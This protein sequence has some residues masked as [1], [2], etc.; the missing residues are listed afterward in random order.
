MPQL[1]TTASVKTVKAEAFGYLNAILYLAPHTIAGGPSVCPS[2][3]PGCR[4]SCLYTSGRGRH[5]NVQAARI[6]K[7]KLWHTDKSLFL[8][9]LNND[10]QLLAAQAEKKALKLAV[11]LNGTSD[12]PFYIYCTSLFNMWKEQGVTF[13]DY[14]KVHGYGKMLPPWWHLTFSLSEKN[15]ETANRLLA[16]GSNVAV[17]FMLGH[18]EPLPDYYLGHKVIDGDIHD[19]RFLDPQPRVVGLR[20]KGD[21]M[22]DET[23]FIRKLS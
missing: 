23:N 6:R 14:T 9:M 3:T 13:Y 10:I 11:R 20:V 5:S 7:T 17:P 1:L 2:S 21:G 18:D 15:E 4:A 16:K 19:L 22:K 8:D 12:I